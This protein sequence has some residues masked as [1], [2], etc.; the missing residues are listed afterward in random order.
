MEKYKIFIPCAGIGS[1]LGSLTKET[2]KALV[3][4]AG[5]EIITHILEKFNDDIEVVIALGYQGGKVKSFLERTYP[6]RKF[7]FV[8]VDIFEGPGSGLGYSMSCCKAFL[9]SPFIFISNDTIV[10]EKIPEPEKNF[11]GYASKRDVS[12]F[13]SIRTEEG[14][15]LELC[16]KGAEGDVFPYIG[17]SGI[18]DWKD[19][20]EV[21]REDKDAFLKIGE[22]AGIKQMIKKGKSFRGIQFTWFD[23]GNI[24]DLEKSEKFLINLSGSLLQ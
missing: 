18:K 19:F 17:L 8:E 6:Q 13:R 9:Q 4:V 2:N 22:S 21:L 7:T 20:W 1:R 10:L 11:I 24:L 16:E 3:K 12:Q 23:T 5:R 14:N 15:V